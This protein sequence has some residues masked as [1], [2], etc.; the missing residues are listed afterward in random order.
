M[1]GLDAA[2]GLF[3]IIMY[4]GLILIFSLP[5]WNKKPRSLRK[6]EAVEKL[7]LAI[8]LTVEAGTRIHISLGNA[9]LLSAYNSSAL[10]GL[11]VLEQVALISQ[12]ADRK[13]IATSGNGAV[14][15][16][17]NSVFK[18]SQEGKNAADQKGSNQGQLSG[19]T[20]LSYAAGTI[21][22]I[23]KDQVSAN[24]FLG[25]YG[26][27][28]ALLGQNS[29]QTKAITLGAS[30]SLTAQAVLFAYSDEPLIGEELYAL[31]A[32][33]SSRRI[34]TASVKVQDFFRWVLIITMLVGA[35]LKFL[36]YV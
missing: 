16:L 26:S 5:R 34:H 12:L 35:V 28:V 36:G 23:R 22:V 29:N 14:A 3:F 10:A 21:N 15:V 32:Y 8:G 7:K 19:T 33:L 4:A 24:V 1:T 31:P 2:I 27:E 18:N 20:P 6:M 13:P 30:D 17:S 9:D 25:H 11:S